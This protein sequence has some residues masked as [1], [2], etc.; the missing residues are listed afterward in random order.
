MAGVELFFFTDNTTAER[1]YYKG[2]STNE[3]LHDLVFRLK[4]VQMKYGCSIILSHIAGTRMI[5][6]GTDGLSRRNMT[7]GVMKGMSMEKIHPF[8]SQRT[9]K[10]RYLVALDQVMG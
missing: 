10:V 4:N 8:A 3:Y 2:S 7:E 9:A 5:A 6:Q 1:A